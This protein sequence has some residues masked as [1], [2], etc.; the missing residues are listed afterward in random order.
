M[1]KFKNGK[2]EGLWKRY[3]SNGELYDVGSYLDGKKTGLWKY[4]DAK[5]NLSHTKTY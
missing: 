2:Q 3:H 5:G 1:G 4:Y